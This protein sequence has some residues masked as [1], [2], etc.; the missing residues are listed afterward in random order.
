MINCLI[1]DDSPV[2]RDILV[3]YCKLLPILQVVGT[4]SDAFGAR[5][6]ILQMPVDLLFLDINM[7]I[8]SGIDLIK[9]LKHPPQIIFTTAYKEY[10]TDAFDLAAC[11]YLVKPFSVERFI[12]AIDRVMEKL[13]KQ[14]STPI[15]KTSGNPNP[16]LL[17]RSEGMI[18]KVNYEQILF[19]EASR[20]NTKV[21]TREETLLSTL[22]LSATEKLL[23]PELFARVHRSFIVNLSRVT[24]LQGN[25]V[26]INKNEI[27]LGSNYK[28]SFMKNLGL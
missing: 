21:V 22:S 11:D 9:T 27:P 28:N 24:S 26:F 17:I 23:P 5:E 3:E 10:A 4:C 6:K 7:P 19:L 1:V 25:R 14:S 16:H 12:I 15:I 20:N 8:L 2:A 13:G 18:N